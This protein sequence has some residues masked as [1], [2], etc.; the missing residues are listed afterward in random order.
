MGSGRG[1]HGHIAI[2]TNSIP[3]IPRAI[4]YLARKGVSFDLSSAKENNGVM[5]AVYL[6]DEVGG[7][8]LHLLR[9]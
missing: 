1:T 2:H 4:A 5:N 6:T 7:F 9:K 8:A 3:I